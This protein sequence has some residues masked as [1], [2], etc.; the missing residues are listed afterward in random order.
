VPHESWQVLARLDWQGSDG[1]RVGRPDYAYRTT[2]EGEWRRVTLEAPA[3]EGAVAVQIQLRLQN[4]PGGTVYWDDLRLE[5]IPDPGAREVVVAAVNLRPREMASPRE[6]VRAFVDFARDRVPEGADVILLPEGITVVG[7]E[8]SYAEVAEPVPGRTTRVLGELARAKG[9]WVVAG[10][11]ER[12]G[13]A[14]YN[15]AVLLDREGRLAGTYRKV[16]LPREEIEGGLTPGAEYPVFTTDFGRVGMMICWDAQYADPARGLVL[17]GAELV[18]VP[19]WGGNETLVRARAIE[20]RVFVATSGYDF[21]TL[22]LDPDGEE[23]A[24]A[25]NDEG[26][27]AVATVDL[28][29]RYLDDWLGDMKGRFPKELRTDVPASRP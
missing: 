6:S 15:T 10:L 27:L 25:E 1:E 7:T 23:M 2:P 21:P 18:L 9:A 8:H 19:I 11:Y 13:S 12:A 4:A 3:P 28:N 16:Y 22:V 24:R 14:I 20:N 5:S 17:G 26:S 29:R